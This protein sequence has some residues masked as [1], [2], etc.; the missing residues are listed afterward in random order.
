MKHG[1]VNLDQAVIGD[2]VWFKRHVPFPAVAGLRDDAALVLTGLSKRSVVVWLKGLIPAST[3]LI[4]PG[5]N[6]GGWSS[7]A[8]SWYWPDSPAHSCPGNA[9]PYNCRPATVSPSSRPAYNG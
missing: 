6:A 3:R 2:R 8:T 9:S 7:R 4:Q 5:A 1:F